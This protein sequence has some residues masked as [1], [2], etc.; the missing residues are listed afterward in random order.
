MVNNILPRWEQKLQ[1]YRKALTRLAEAVEE[2]NKR[3]LNDIEADGLIQ[4]SS[5]PLNWLGS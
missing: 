3:Q 2:M 1:S 4:R 5:L